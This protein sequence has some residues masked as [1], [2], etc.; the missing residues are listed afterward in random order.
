VSTRPPADPRRAVLTGFVRCDVL[1][2]DEQGIL[3]FLT[4][5]C[6]WLPRDEEYLRGLLH[7]VSLTPYDLR[8]NPFM[9]TALAVVYLQQKRLPHQRADL[10]EA[11]VDWLSI[12]A[13]DRWGEPGYPRHFILDCLQRLALAMQ[14]WK[15]G[16]VGKEGRVT[17]VS[18]NDAAPLIVEQFDGGIDEARKFLERAR[19]ASGI[20]TL[21]DGQLAFWHKLF[22]EYLAARMMIFLHPS[23]ARTAV[24]LRLIYSA[25][26]REVLPLAAVRMKAD[27]G[28]L[29]TLFAALIEDAS[30]R[31]LPDQAHAVGVLG[32]MLRDLKST[33]W[34]LRPAANEQYQALLGQVMRIFDPRFAASIPLQSRLEAAEALGAACD[35]RLAMPDEPEY[36]VSIAE[37][38]ATTGFHIGRFPVTVYEYGRYM[39]AQTDAPKPVDWDNQEQHP[40]W[41]V[42]RVS[43]HDA[44]AYCA[45]ASRPDWRVTLPTDEQWERAARGA[46]G[47]EYPWGNEAPTPERANYRDTGI[48]HKPTPV[49][50]FPAGNTPDGVSDM[51]GN[52]WEWTRSPW[53]KDGSGDNRTVRGAAFVSD[54]RVLRASY[55]FRLGPG[56]RDSLIGFRCVRE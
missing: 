35:H 36:W 51:A 23:E 44:M 27:Y 7:D 42:T 28:Y 24:A 37:D 38:K 18:V 54:A 53:D 31:P 6:H 33:S 43:W 41:P 48:R 9:L 12:Q 20:L 11:I 55:R 46:E 1:P 5:W 39:A 13:E 8:S 16:K 32:S 22:Q 26:G 40:N 4:T 21:R 30:A 49:G 29:P 34:K 56:S 19:E 15:E 14:E 50:L 10:Y 52:V 17:T 3:Q 2:L 45:W 47:R 25:E